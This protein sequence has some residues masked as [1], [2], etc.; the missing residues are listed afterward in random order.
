MR[1]G[2]TGRSGRFG[3]IVASKV[4]GTLAL[5]TAAGAACGTTED[6]RVEVRSS[7]LT[8]LDVMWKARRRADDE[9][10]SCA[11]QLDQVARDARAT[12]WL[13]P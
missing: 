4:V 12:R 9:S 1:E 6:E 8:S 5:A 10:G 7:A 2:R 11:G 3:A 13:A